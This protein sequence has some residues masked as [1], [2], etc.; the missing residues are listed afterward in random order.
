MQKDPPTSAQTTIKDTALSF[1][2]TTLYMLRAALRRASGTA[3]VGVLALIVQDNRVLLIKHRGGIFPWG[4]PGGGVHPTE[5]PAAAARREAH[6][7]TGCIVRLERLHGFYYHQYHN[8]RDC[9]FVYRC[10]PLTDIAPPIWDI[11]IAT[12]RYFPLDQIPRET[13]LVSRN[14]IEEYR[15]TMDSPTPPPPIIELPPDPTP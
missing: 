6:E 5:T 10:T 3:V 7:E 2:Y 12:A 15:A 11:E 13:N 1:A 8:Y 9:L 14:R 4:L